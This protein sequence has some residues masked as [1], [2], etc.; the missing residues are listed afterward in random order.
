[1]Y[2]LGLNFFNLYLKPTK[3]MTKKYLDPR[4]IIT[5]FYFEKT[6]RGSGEN[7]YLLP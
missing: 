6:N 2:V 4:K 5:K 3:T 7:G 1:M